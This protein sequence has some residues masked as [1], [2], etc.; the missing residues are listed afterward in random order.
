MSDVPPAVST[1][2]ASLPPNSSLQYDEVRATSQQRMKHQNAPNSAAV[3]PPTRVPTSTPQVSA[4]PLAISTPA[5]PSPP[6]PR[7]QVH[8]TSKQRVKHQ[9]APN[10]APML[11]ITR[12]ATQR[13]VSWSSNPC[14]SLDS[15]DG[16]AV[17]TSG[18]DEP[19]L[20][21]Q[22]TGYAS[23]P[24]ELGVPENQNIPAALYEPLDLSQ[25]HTIDLLKRLAVLIPNWQE[26]AHQLGLDDQE[27]EALDTNYV[28]WQE[29]CFQM[30]KTWIEKDD[31]A[32]CAKLVKELRNMHR[33][34]LETLIHQH[35][36]QLSKPTTGISTLT[37]DA[38]QWV[39]DIKTLGD[40]IENIHISIKALLEHKY[41][42]AT[43]RVSYNK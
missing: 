40:R 15:D 26:L 37:D 28:M 41:K 4:V 36:E 9:N 24:E 12:V 42:T 18:T 5:T 2:A 32:S 21:R 8:A 25:K 13:S 11:P 34:D 23:H 10:S 7:D 22:D 17:Y 39:V 43:I 38:N 35:M 31:N 30:L 33:P 6:L 16:G 19:Q 3:L 27:I 14:S 1:P 29:Q 20:Q